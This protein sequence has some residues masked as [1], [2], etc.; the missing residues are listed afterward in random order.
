MTIS[1]DNTVTATGRAD[2]R[3]MSEPGMYASSTPAG[4]PVAGRHVVGHHDGRTREAAR[5]PAETARWPGEAARWPAV[6]GRAVRTVRVVTVIGRCVLLSRGRRGRLELVGRLAVLRQV[7]TRRLLAR[8]H[9]VTGDPV[10][11]ARERERHDH[12]VRH[13]GQDGARLADEQVVP[14]AEEEPV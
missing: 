11:D 13:H 12:R 8:V 10:D 6:S 2:G 4:L 7:E 1:S 14:A 3:R 9:P 5:W